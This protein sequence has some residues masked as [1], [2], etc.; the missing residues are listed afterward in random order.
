MPGITADIVN[1]SSTTFPAPQP[2]GGHPTY[3]RER[4]MSIEDHRPVYRLSLQVAVGEPA[5]GGHR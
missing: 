1:A 2:H 3:D 5:A 4:P